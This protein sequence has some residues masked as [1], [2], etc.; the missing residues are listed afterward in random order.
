MIRQIRQRKLSM[1]RFHKNLAGGK[2]L[3]AFLFWDR[4]FCW[5][6]LWAVWRL[7]VGDKRSLLTVLADPT[8]TLLTILRLV[9]VIFWPL[10]RPEYLR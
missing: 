5:P 1:Q 2:I 8:H 3:Y 10:V 7:S 9:L 4:E 6:F